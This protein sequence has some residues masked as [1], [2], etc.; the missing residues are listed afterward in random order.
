MDNQRRG[1]EAKMHRVQQI[2]SW[3]YH[4]IFREW[5]CSQ[6][7]ICFLISSSLKTLKRIGVQYVFA[8]WIS[9]VTSLNSAWVPAHQQCWKP[10]I[11]DASASNSIPAH[12]GQRHDMGRPDSGL[13]RKNGTL[14]IST[15]SMYLSEA[16]ASCSITAASMD[17]SS[18]NF[19][20]DSS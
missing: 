16:H 11:R 13:Y 8:D 2:Y 10:S 9:Q 15:R 20:M 7:L 4:W 17:S 3:L 5:S 18:I 6:G 14:L 1:E 12:Q 19:S